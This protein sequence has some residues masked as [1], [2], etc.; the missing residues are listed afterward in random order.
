MHAKHESTNAIR[1]ANADAL[2]RASASMRSKAMRFMMSSSASPSS[3][4]ASDDVDG[5]GRMT[6]TAVRND[7]ARRTLTPTT[8]STSTATPHARESNAADNLFPSLSRA[9]ARIA[10]ETARE[11]ARDGANAMGDVDG[12]DARAVQRR[13]WGVADAIDGARASAEDVGDVV[14][15]AKHAA[16]EDPG[17]V[18]RGFSSLW[19][20][21]SWFGSG[22]AFAAAPAEIASVSY[23]QGV[24]GA[25]GA[26]DGGQKL[27][28][29]GGAS[30]QNRFIVNRGAR[31]PFAP[32]SAAA[33]PDHVDKASVDASRRDEA[34]AWK[35]TR[36]NTSLVPG[37][38]D[39][40]P[41]RKAGE[42]SYR[43]FERGEAR[44]MTEERGVK[45][46]FDFDAKRWWIIRDGESK[47]LSYTPSAAT[48]APT[49]GT[50]ATAID[51]NALSDDVADV[52]MDASDASTDGEVDDEG[53]EMREKAREERLRRYQP[54]YDASSARVVVRERERRDRYAEEPEY[55]HETTA[56]TKLTSM[57]PE[58]KRADT[59]ARCAASFDP[60]L[61]AID[62]YWVPFTCS[63]GL[64]AWI[65]LANDVDASSALT[66]WVNGDAPWP[67]IRRL[68]L[69]R[70]RRGIPQNA[71][72]PEID[73]ELR[74]LVKS[75]L[76]ARAAEAETVRASRAPLPRARTVNADGGEANEAQTNVVNALLRA[77][78]ADDDD[79]G[80]ENVTANAKIK[81]LQSKLEASIR[82][83]FSL[84]AEIDRLR[85]VIAAAGL[86]ADAIA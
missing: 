35:V 14:V 6:S 5:A 33:T 85:A 30:C 57:T 38:C 27:R 4:S 23:D 8:A 70:D 19:S 55:K 79:G 44:R 36:W 16:V 12:A 20:S 2:A 52:D 17:E 77:A 50:T 26:S 78:T 82:E 29:I 67:V 41:V 68:D 75:E 9:D 32:A 28:A 66:L 3:E 80:A 59:T 73:A 22:G 56:K 65:E 62:A 61:P 58:T 47:E 83:K 86:N 60:G 48:Q 42:R 10:R 34:D 76:R 51:V 15:D 18:E 72:G 84:R 31:D 37:A 46:E 13:R 71:P 11:T 40:T 7:I 25:K 53:R 74:A 24:D 39:E 64:T 21:S 81:V 63:N 43:S 45:F 49:T 1:S 54:S 69:G